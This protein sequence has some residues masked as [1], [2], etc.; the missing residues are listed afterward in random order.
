MP[1]A[2]SHGDTDGPPRSLGNSRCDTTTGPHK[3]KNSFSLTVLN[4]STSP[5][6]SGSVASHH[7]R[8]PAAHTRI[9]SP[10]ILCMTSIPLAIE[11]S[12][13]TAAAATSGHAAPPHWR[14]THS[15]DQVTIGSSW[16]MTWDCPPPCH[17]SGSH[18]TDGQ[19]GQNPAY[20]CEHAPAEVWR[21]RLRQP[22]AVSRRTP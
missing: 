17:L 11:N 3:V 10:N 2:S 16:S 19:F 14:I 1:H 8:Y 9:I 15:I 5:S 20:N 7:A 21:H 12:H 4:R 18:F 13:T 22:R 6:G